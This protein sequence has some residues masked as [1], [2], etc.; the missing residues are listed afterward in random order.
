MVPPYGWMRGTDP[1]PFI[2]IM[3]FVSDVLGLYENDRLHRLIGD[4]SINVV[5]C[6][7]TVVHQQFLLQSTSIFGGTPAQEVIATFLNKIGQKN[8]QRLFHFR[9]DS[10]SG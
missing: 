4:H 2:S 5:G 3:F 10:F 7:K 6:S 8:I 9:A 1:T